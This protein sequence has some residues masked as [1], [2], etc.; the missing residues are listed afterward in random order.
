MRKRSTPKKPTP[1]KRNSADLVYADAEF[2]HLTEDEADIMVAESRMNDLERPFE[3]YLAAHGY[4]V[5]T[6]DK[7]RKGSSTKK[8]SVAECSGKMAKPH[9]KR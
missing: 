8:R 1:P 3:E 2:P 9:I 5:V 7:I 6:G 4:D